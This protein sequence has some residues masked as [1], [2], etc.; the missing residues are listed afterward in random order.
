[1]KT[2]NVVM[3]IYKMHSILYIFWNM[4]IHLKKLMDLTW[5]FAS[6]IGSFPIAQYLIEKGANIE[7]QNKEK[8][9]PLHYACEEGHLPIVQ[10]LFEN[11][12]ILNRKMTEKKLLFIILHTMVK[13]M[14]LNTW[15][16]KEQTKM[17]KTKMGKQ[18]TM[19][20][21]IGI[22]QINPQKIISKNLNENHF[23]EPRRLIKLSALIL[24]AGN[25]SFQPPFW[26]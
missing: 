4:D 2:M 7:A 24:D 11:V 18:H 14:L 22:K 26:Y 23:T 17:P 15:F 13:L 1:M 3:F 5:Y 9:T 8:Q 10:Y 16:P 20:H 21:V 25:G 19:L 12:L 6:Y